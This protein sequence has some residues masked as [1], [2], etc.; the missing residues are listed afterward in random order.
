MMYNLLKKTAIPIFFLIVATHFCTNICM[1]LDI[2]ELKFKADTIITENNAKAFINEVLNTGIEDPHSIF[3]Q[4]KSTNLKEAWI[5]WLNRL[6]QAEQEFVDSDLIEFCD[7]ISQRVPQETLKNRQHSFKDRFE[8]RHIKT[9]LQQEAQKSFKECTRP[10]LGLG[11][12][13]LSLIGSGLCHFDIYCNPDI[14]ITLATGSLFLIMPTTKT[15][16]PLKKQWDLRHKIY[17]VNQ[18][19]KEIDTTLAKENKKR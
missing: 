3:T 7:K 16:E 8:T 6:R 19:L 18:V 4:S 5:K 14:I 1:Q 17:I 11:F 12:C 13:M 9:Y 2:T 10:L 15:I